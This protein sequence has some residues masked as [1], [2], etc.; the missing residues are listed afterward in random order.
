[1]GR[2]GFYTSPVSLTFPPPARHRWRTRQRRRVHTRPRGTRILKKLGSP[3]IP[4]G[5]FLLAA[6]LI[7]TW[8]P[9]RV[10]ALDFAPVYP[11]VYFIS[12]IQ[13]WRFH[14]NRMLL[15]LVMLALVDRVLIHY[16]G[17]DAAGEGIGHMVF[18][19]VA[20]LLPLNLLILGLLPE[21]G[22]V[23]VQGIAQWA[24]VVV[25]PAVVINLVRGG[26]YEALSVLDVSFLGGLKPAWA[27]VPDL[28]F[29]IFGIALA[30]FVFQYFWRPGAERKTM[31]WVFIACFMALTTGYGGVES[32]TYLAS[33]G[34]TTTT[35]WRW[36]TSITSRLSTTST[37]TM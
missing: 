14:R 31:L 3:V 13:C 16:T 4:E 20:V 30:T 7:I 10:W 18:N 37:A 6:Y 23:T 21:R 19:V 5:I 36:S 26:Q 2:A 35:P 28:S 9:A 8:Q 22:P 15:A 17:I 1:M 32:T 11:A 27:N 24:S 29:L 33:A 25:Q 12:I 34:L